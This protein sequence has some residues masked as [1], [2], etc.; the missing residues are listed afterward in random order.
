MQIPVLNPASSPRGAKRGIM[1]HK[2]KSKGRKRKVSAKVLAILAAGRAKMAAKRARK[3]APKARKPRKAHKVRAAKGGLHRPVVRVKKGRLYRRPGS[4][5]IHPHATFANPFLGEIA[6]L[7]NPR[8]RRSHRRHRLA[9]ANPPGVRQLTGGIREMASMSFVQDAVSA[10][11]GFVL[12]NVVVAWLPP[13]MRDATWKVYG[14]KA[15]VVAAL[16]AGAGVASKKVAKMVLLGGGISIMLDLYADFVQPMIQRTSAP[17]APA[18]TSAYY[19]TAEDRGVGAY[20]GTA[21][22]RGMG[23]SI[24][25]TFAEGWA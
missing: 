12:P 4:T 10:A 20:F 25:D 8:K 13:V 23:A 1:A 18:G 9:W 16:A 3:A 2:K 17:A 24:A 22:D 6:M 11:A 14:S 19:G 15:L 5:L 21:D 7:G